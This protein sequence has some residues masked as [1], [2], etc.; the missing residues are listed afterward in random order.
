MNCDQKEHKYCLYY[1]WNTTTV[2]AQSQPC[3]ECQETERFFFTEP[4]DSALSALCARNLLV[5]TH[6]NARNCIHS[7]VKNILAFNVGAKWSSS[8]VHWVLR[9]MKKVVVMADNSMS[10]TATII[11]SIFLYILSLCLQTIV[12]L[13]SFKSFNAHTNHWDNYYQAIQAIQIIEF[14]NNL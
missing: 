13:V 4:P 2:S 1:W 10:F 14:Y 9:S 12:S 6:F 5:V 7:V 8:P 11:D 3:S